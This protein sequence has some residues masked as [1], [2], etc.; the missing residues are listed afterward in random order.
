MATPDTDTSAAASSA[1]KANSPITMVVAGV[2]ALALGGLGVAA[3]QM[4]KG[5]GN[6]PEMAATENSEDA[7]SKDAESQARDEAVNAALSGTS[8]K[9]TITVAP[10]EDPALD[11]PGAGKSAVTPDVSEDPSLK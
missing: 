5:K 9:D 11:A 10:K 1:S 2:L 7:K 3:W 4:S 8:S 6:A